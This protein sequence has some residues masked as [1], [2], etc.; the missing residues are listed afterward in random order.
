MINKG[1]G[2]RKEPVYILDLNEDFYEFEK[3]DGL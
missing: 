1:I 2:V 3:D